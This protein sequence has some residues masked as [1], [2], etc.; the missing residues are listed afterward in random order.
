MM[1]V[2]PHNRTDW[3]RIVWRQRLYERAM[4]HADEIHSKELLEYAT[5]EEIAT[6]YAELKAYYKTLKG[7]DCQP[8]RKEMRKHIFEYMDRGDV[9]WRLIGDEPK[10]IMAAIME[11]YEA[12]LHE[13]DSLVA[14]A[15]DAMQPTDADYQRYVDYC[16][17]LSG[18]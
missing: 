7:D 16:S 11:R 18:R 15:V 2:Q 13:W 1:I 17:G 9:P 3:E 8:D 12:D 10:R 14:A 4:H 6:A 5:A